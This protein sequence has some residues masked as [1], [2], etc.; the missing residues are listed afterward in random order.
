VSTET[1]SIGDLTFLIRRSER[2]KS[3]GLTVDR[4]EKLLLHAPVHVPGQQIE[5]WARSR[6]L[7]VYQKLAVKEPALPVQARA[8]LESGDTVYYLGQAYRLKF[9]ESQIVPVVCQAGWL[10]L[11]RSER[12]DV[13]RV[14]RRWFETAGT[15]WM[16]Q[17]V[18]LLSQRFG[19]LPSEVEVRELGNR[20]GSCTSEGKLYFNGRLMQMPMR[21]IDYVIAH[22]LVHLVEPK[23]DSNFWSKLDAIMPDA[24]IRKLELRDAGKQYL[25]L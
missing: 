12:K 8:A 3:L 1:L 4:R 24:E 15:R 11:R 9:V 25:I 2:R 13:V 7:W 6:L 20:W 23:H 16:I 10:R 17:R 18:D 21:L 14:L 22:E 5:D 19:L